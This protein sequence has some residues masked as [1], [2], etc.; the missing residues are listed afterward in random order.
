MNSAAEFREPI[1]EYPEATIHDW[2]TGHSLRTGT[3]NTQ[4][5]TPTL[6]AN[7][8]MSKH[9]ATSLL[10]IQ[11]TT[12]RLLFSDPQRSGR[13]LTSV[14]KTFT[15][16]LSQHLLSDSNRLYVLWRPTARRPVKNNFRAGRG[17]ILGQL[18]VS[19]VKMPLRR[20]RFFKILQRRYKSINLSSGP[21]Y[22]LRP[23]KRPSCAVFSVRHYHVNRTA[24]RFDVGPLR[25]FRTCRH[26]ES[27][28]PHML[29]H[30]KEWSQC[31]KGL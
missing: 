4:A 21:K 31:R 15:L 22:D 27:R 9:Y 18:L 17:P 23:E 19:N 24:L 3:R 11:L 8:P 5:H 12:H 2:G 30:L 28:R 7:V 1:P 20:A 29:P 16:S 25:A 26:G 6:E 13:N 14:S 10:Q